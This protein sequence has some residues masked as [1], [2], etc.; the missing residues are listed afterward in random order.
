ML[1]YTYSNISAA[2]GYLLGH[3][4]NSYV[5]GIFIQHHHKCDD[6]NHLLPLAHRSFCAGENV[7]G[8]GNQQGSLYKLNSNADERY[9]YWL[10]GFIEGE[11]SWSISFKQF[12]K[13]KTVF[14][15]PSVSGLHRKK[16]VMPFFLC[17]PCHTY[18]CGFRSYF[19]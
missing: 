1:P 11:G 4:M 17:P 18:K 2:P 7:N 13:S 12:K 14:H 3:P 8:A 10:G 6:E 9:K 15:P 19:I 5:T 16:G